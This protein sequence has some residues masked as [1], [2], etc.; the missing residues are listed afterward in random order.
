M[1]DDKSWNWGYGNAYKTFEIDPKQ[2]C[3]VVA[4]PDQH[5]SAVIGLDDHTK[6]LP[7]FRKFGLLETV[8]HQL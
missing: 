3:I 6:L 2:G 5:V 8:S 1:F 7:M 4:R